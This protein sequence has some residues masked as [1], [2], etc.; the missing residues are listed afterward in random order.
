VLSD[1]QLH[2]HLAQA[3]RA[4][5]C[6]RFDSRRTTATLHELFEAELQSRRAARASA[7]MP[8]G[9]GVGT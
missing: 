2:C 8:F 7:L 6:E 4:R 5:I 9:D 1:S 3:A